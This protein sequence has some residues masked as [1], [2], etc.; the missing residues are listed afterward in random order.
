[1]FI[2]LVPASYFYQHLTSV[3]AYFG[4]RCWRRKLPVGSYRTLCLFNHH[5]FYT[6]SSLQ[7]LTLMLMLCSRLP[8]SVILFRDRVFTGGGGGETRGRDWILKWGHSADPDL[9][10]VSGVHMKNRNPDIIDAHADWMNTRQWR[11][12]ACESQETPKQPSRG[13]QRVIEQL[14]SQPRGWCQGFG[15][16]L[17]TSCE[18]V[19][20]YRWSHPVCGALLGQK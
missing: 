5:W 14:L 15:L 1:M 16:R 9:G 19:N 12:N 7:I 18:S 17:L 2:K 6:G 10:P 13:K 8:H 20:V 3:V 11:E 4:T